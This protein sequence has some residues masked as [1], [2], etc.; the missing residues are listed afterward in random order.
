MRGFVFFFERVE[1]PTSSSLRRHRTLRFTQKNIQA[2]N[3][4]QRVIRVYGRYLLIFMLYTEFMSGKW[5]EVS[6]EFLT[7]LFLFSEAGRLSNLSPISSF[8][9]LEFN[10]HRNN[11]KVINSMN[12]EGA[13][14]KT[15][16][17]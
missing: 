16:P 15:S 10:L 11:F 8:S 3:M 7:L 14:K 17:N 1:V 9:V 6:N 5:P 2:I 13:K 4:D 12:E